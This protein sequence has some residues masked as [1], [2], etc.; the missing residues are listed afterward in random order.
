MSPRMK[1]DEKCLGCIILSEFCLK[2][3]F[4]Y[5]FGKMP[6]H[7]ITE[8]PRH[9]EP[10]DVCCVMDTAHL[11]YSCKNGGKGEKIEPEYNQSSRANTHS[12]EL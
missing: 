12:Q 3:F 11:W 4:K 8:I 7:T 10:P 9:S 1:P 6:M 2:Y 5:N